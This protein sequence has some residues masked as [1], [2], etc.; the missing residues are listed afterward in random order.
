M[1]IQQLLQSAVLRAKALREELGDWLGLTAANNVLAKNHSQMNL[2]YQ[3][4]QNALDDLDRDCQ[5]LLNSTS[6]GT[7]TTDRFRRITAVKY[8]L[9]K[10]YEL[11]GIYRAWFTQ[12]FVDRFRPYLHA[13]DAIAYDC[14]RAVEDQLKSLSIDCTRIDLRSYPITA[15]DGQ[16]NGPYTIQRGKRFCPT[17]SKTLPVPMIA[18]H[19]N[20]QTMVWNCLA[21]HHEV[22]HDLD[23]DLGEPSGE[24]AE[25]LRKELQVRRRVQIRAEA[26][27]RWSREIVADY[28]GVMLGG[29]AYL[30]FMAT[31]LA[32]HP[33]GVLALGNQD[34]HPVPYLRIPLIAKFV[35]S[36]W[37][38]N[39]TDVMDYTQGIVASWQTLYPNATQPLLDFQ[40]DF[41]LVVHTLKTLPLNCLT[42]KQSNRH[43]LAK[44]CP[45]PTDL[46]PRQLEAARVLLG[47][48]SSDIELKSPRL[49]PGA[50]QLAFEQDP[51]NAS[52][53]ASAL[54]AIIERL[55]EGQLGD[56]DEQLQQR[57]ID[58]FLGDFLSDVEDL[59]T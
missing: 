19:W 52:L 46:F 2:V 21:I 22:G 16:H 32:R 44:L 49:I 40:Q 59:G 15:F 26:W 43:S 17:Q 37:D 55:P 14:Y 53:N 20:T 29:P 6:S 27:P 28:F 47:D 54:Q 45:S 11:W 4:F 24:I 9:D 36:V 35:E 33:C 34:V 57:L 58:R 13:T 50:A 39:S 48:Q 42:D 30:G 3:T 41:D 38:G 18:V 23:K 10:T 8:R 1:I 5:L 51:E 12:R 56:D 25:H 31:Y 7:I